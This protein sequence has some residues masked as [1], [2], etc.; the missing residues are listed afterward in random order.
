MLRA[1][2]R[3]NDALDIQSVVDPQAESG[4]PH[5]GIL[6][7]FAESAVRRSEDL[8]ERR[9]D[10]VAAIGEPALIDAAGIV[11]NFQRMVRIA[12]ACGIPLDDWT[13]KR[14][15]DAKRQLALHRFKSAANTP[16]N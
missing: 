10:I 3:G 14:T 9:E 1:S 2:S 5:G 11:A 16:A 12:D 6:T 13:R 4:I 7:A 8:P 15:A